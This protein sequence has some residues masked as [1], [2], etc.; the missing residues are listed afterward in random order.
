MT[1]TGNVYGEALY[2][3]ACD[4]GVSEEIL[5]ELMA[6]EESFSQEPDFLR[7]LDSPNLP[8]AERCRILDDSFRGKLQPYLLNFLKI[9][10]E[11]SYARHFGDCCAAYRTRYNEDHGILPVTAVSAI[12]LSD[13]Q[14]AA[15]TE[16]LAGL[17]GKTIQL[18]NRVDPAVLGGIRLDYHGIRMDDT[19]VHRLDAIR[20]MLKDTAL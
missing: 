8:K 19:V 10:A 1:H 14:C 18:H 15:L 9:L 20:A 7:L 16:K 6:L 4:E 5:Q 11:K 13:S 2:T 12:P 17:T 3:L